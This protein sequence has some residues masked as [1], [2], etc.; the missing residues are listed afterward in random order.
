MAAGSDPGRERFFGGK[1]LVTS[2]LVVVTSYRDVMRSRGCRANGQK[3]GLTGDVESEVCCLCLK[4]LKVGKL[5][6]IADRG[7][8]DIRGTFN[9]LEGSIRG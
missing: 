8:E 4:G 2:S 1:L 5:G 3:V 9:G 7:R 6:F